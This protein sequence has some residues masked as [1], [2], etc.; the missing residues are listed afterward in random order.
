MLCSK[1]SMRKQERNRNEVIMAANLGP[2]Q[3]RLV[4]DINLSYNDKAKL[5]TD[6]MSM[7]DDQKKA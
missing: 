3:G 5:V 2:T 4:K 7:T 1:S 6:N